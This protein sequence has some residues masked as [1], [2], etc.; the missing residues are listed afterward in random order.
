MNPKYA[1]GMNN[2]NLEKRFINDYFAKFSSNHTPKASLI[3]GEEKVIQELKSN[4][5]QGLE[6]KIYFL[7][8]KLK[9]NMYNFFKTFYAFAVS[10]Q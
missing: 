1:A 6:V 8:R 5:E 4:A 9:K 10:K 7:K 2:G 3:E